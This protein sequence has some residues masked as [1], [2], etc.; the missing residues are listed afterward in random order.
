MPAMINRRLVPLLALMLLAFASPILG[1][2]A[3]VGGF[4]L[5][6]YR[7]EVPVLYDGPPVDG[8]TPTALDIDNYRG[9]VLVERDPA[10]TDVE[11]TA[12]AVWPR[13]EGR[14]E[15]G[16]AVSFA[17]TASHAVTGNRGVLRIAT[18]PEPQSPKDLRIHLKVRTPSA[19]GVRVVNRGG[20]VILEGTRGA[21]TV[22]CV[23][24]PG[25]KRPDIQWRTDR[26]VTD[27]VD[28]R[29]DRG[30]VTLVMPPEGRG[31]VDLSS[32]EGKVIFRTRDGNTTDQVRAQKQSLAVTWNG[33]E[34]PITLRSETRS[35][36]AIAD[37]S[38]MTL[39]VYSGPGS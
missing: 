13:T 26:P 22:S 11:I 7:A 30:L 23:S 21:T 34:N 24:L 19:A 18:S 6:T 8:L 17:T 37:P 10:L 31:R 16:E 36:R 9:T 28:L 38:P 5:G 39:T 12:V 25:G 1:G 33:G 27:P 4:G 29:S 20:A 3:G 14:P 15:K 2:C 35:V 32:G